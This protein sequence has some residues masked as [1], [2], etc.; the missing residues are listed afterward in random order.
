[1]FDIVRPLPFPSRRG[2]TVVEVH[3]DGAHWQDR[4]ADSRG[5][6]NVWSLID[7]KAFQMLSA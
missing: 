3:A 5:E 1:M 6:V 2:A 7:Q 4:I